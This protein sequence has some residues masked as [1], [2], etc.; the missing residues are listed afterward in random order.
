MQSGI[1]KKPGLKKTGPRAKSVQAELKTFR[2]RRDL[3]LMA[4]NRL[5]QFKLGPR[6]QHWGRLMT[7]HQIGML[8]GPRGKGKTWFGLGLAAAMST[9]M[10]FLGHAPRNPRRVCYLDGEMDFA[11]LQA[12]IKAIYNGFQAK[13]SDKLKLFT[14][15]LFTDLL[16]AINTPEGQ[17]LVDEMIGK[18]WDVLIID[19]YSAWSS[20]GRETSESWV[21][22]MRWMLSHK[23]A[24]RSVIIVHH[25]G[26]N[27]Q[28]RGSSRHEDALDWSITLKPIESTERDDALRFVLEWKKCRNLTQKETPPISVCM[29]KA[30]D[31][32]LTWSWTPGGIANPDVAKAHKLKAS[33]M[34]VGEIAKELGV[35][36][37]TVTRWTKE[38]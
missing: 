1:S 9:G 25:T 13:F 20:D 19:N 35:N 11:T 28:Q 17:K 5:V 15:E 38:K 16:P 34:P 21:P 7:A 33:G 32:R 12:R 8:V 36:R 26:K 6:K 10:S 22:L 31:G 24:G 4:V 14:P 29:E 37:T 18:E 3:K 23:H 27:G 2:P 30:E